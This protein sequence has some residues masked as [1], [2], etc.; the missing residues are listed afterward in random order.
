MSFFSS[1][2]SLIHKRR[3]RDSQDMIKV[4]DNAEF[5]ESEKSLKLDFS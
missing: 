1:V 2:V 5:S 3:I 4:I